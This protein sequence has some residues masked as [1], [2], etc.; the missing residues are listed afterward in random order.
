MCY[1]K[2]LNNSA[3]FWPDYQSK[4]KCKKRQMAFE[5][6]V[7][8]CLITI[9]GA[10]SMP[11]VL[12]ERFSNHHSIKI[13]PKVNEFILAALGETAGIGSSTSNLSAGYSVLERNGWMEDKDAK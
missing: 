4:G 7:L 8:I 5:H 6:L 9:I 1:S 12:V 10:I 11:L 13:I 2:T 3:F